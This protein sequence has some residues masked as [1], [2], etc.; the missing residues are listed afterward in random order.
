L[1]GVDQYPEALATTY[2]QTDDPYTLFYRELKAELED[3]GLEIVGS[4]VHANAVVRID[5]DET[6]ERVLTVSGRNVPTEYDVFYNVSYSVSLNGEEVLP[7]T[8]LSLT[9]AFTYDATT[10][11]GKNREAEAIRE[12]LAAN[13]VRQVSQQLALL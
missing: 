4:P 9:Q 6:G 1:Q 13:L 2:I 10:V 3:G 11:L 5:R 12:A 7:N 8:P